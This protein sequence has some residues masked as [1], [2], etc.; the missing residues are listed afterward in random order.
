[1][2]IKSEKKKAEGLISSFKI[3]PGSK[4]N[5]AIFRLPFYLCIDF[6]H[7]DIFYL[8]TDSPYFHK[9]FYSSCHMAVS[10]KSVLLSCHYLYK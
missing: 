3:Y 2:L 6:G 1:M 9:A 7:L 4:Q 5:C 8:K 10:T